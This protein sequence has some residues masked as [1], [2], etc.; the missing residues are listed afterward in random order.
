MKALIDEGIQIG[1][2]T[3]GTGRLKGSVVEEFDLV[4]VDV[5]GSPSDY[6][7]M[8]Q[9][10]TEST[11]KPVELNEAGQLECTDG[12]CQI[13]E[14]KI[15]KIQSMLYVKDAIESYKW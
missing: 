5:V 14:A 7:A 8:L 6:N 13:Q 12:S 2:S 3:R 10:I 11:E 15:G 9:G 1:V 4:T